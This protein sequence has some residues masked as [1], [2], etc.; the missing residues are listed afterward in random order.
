MQLLA[1]S[2]LLLFGLAIVRFLLYKY[3]IL[4]LVYL[5]NLRRKLQFK[6]DPWSLVD[7]QKTGLA[8]AFL[9][10][11]ELAEFTLVE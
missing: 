10:T 11:I 9:I 2:D 7:L 5:L 3:K 1:E 4:E 8:L 6:S